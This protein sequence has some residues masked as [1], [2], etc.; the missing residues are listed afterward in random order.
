[1]QRRR[2]SL[3]VGV[4]AIV[5]L[6]AGTAGAANVSARKAQDPAAA[7]S[8]TTPIKHLV[9][10]FQE[11]ISF[12]HY[13]GTYPNA[14]NPVGEPAFTAKKGTPTV[15]GLTA[16]LLTNNPNLSNPQRLDRSQA[17][18]CDQGHGYTQEQAAEDFGAMDKFVQ[19]TNRQG[20][21]HPLT[22]GECLGTT[23]TPGNFPVMDYYDGNTVTALWN[24]AQRFAMSDNSWDTGFGPSTP[25]AMEVTSGQTFGVVC[26]RPGASFAI[27]NSPGNCPA[28]PAGTTPA[29]PGVV[30]QPPAHAGTTFSD[31]DPYYDICSND[32]ITSVQGGRNI[33]DELN[34]AGLTWG[35]FT[36]GFAAPGYVPGNPASDNLSGGH[37][38]AECTAGHI[39]IG[40]TSVQADYIPHHEPFQY[41][42]STA[43]PLHLPPL[44]IANIGHQDQAN[45]QYDLADFNA[46]VDNNTMP[47]VS[48]L[49][50]P[51]FQ[52]GHGGY[53]DPLDEQTFLVDTL[54]HLQKSPEW[55][56]TAVV[57]AY[58]DSDGWYDHVPPTIL[59]QSQSSIDVPGFC[60]GASA[61]IPVG[62]GGQQEQG[63]CGYS[64]RLPLLVISP[65]SKQNFVD[66]TTTDQSS[67]VRFI[68]D[69]WLQ[70]ARIGNGSADALAGSLENMLDFH[71][72]STSALILDP[73][74]G[75]PAKGGKKH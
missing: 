53:S 47:S 68:E 46:A 25:G 62:F 8:T 26:S 57:I 17:H 59:F 28:A 33:G 4:T 61:T 23:P 41:Y 32:S 3:A 58:D 64:Q 34:S 9:V 18:T 2:T 19:N 44:S 22:L 6:A 38:G 55:K 14:A 7:A 36:G 21:G 37:A 71:K 67:V 60:G 15:N 56:S 75:L 72:A 10:I 45:H 65:F 16:G 66:G 51:A 73:S 29:N 70:S 35:F 50:A 49:K 48:Y 43:N 20:G 42:Q 24:Y 11:N 1:M 27:L 54:N 13:F 69:N 30:Q 39:G 40:N 63:R 5:G 74:T 31:S 52:D 12:D